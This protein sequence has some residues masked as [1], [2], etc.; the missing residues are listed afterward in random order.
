MTAL[1]LSLLGPGT[2]YTVG[3]FI[4]PTTQKELALVAYLALERRPQ[5]RQHLAELLWG[6]GRGHNLRQALYNLR[7]LPDAE[8]WLVDDGCCVAVQATSDVRDLEL[9]LAAQQYERALYLW[10]PT[11]L[12]QAPKTLLAG[13]EL[14][15]A[16]TFDEWLAL[17]RTRL[18]HLYLEAL[19]GYAEALETR[20]EYAAARRMTEQLLMHDELNETAWQALMRLHHRLGQTDRALATYDECRFV[21]RRE[22]GVEPLPETTALATAL[23]TAARQASRPTVPTL[24][25]PSSGYARAART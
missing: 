10:H 6:E 22:L 5:R 24:P 4:T 13:L 2:L 19:Q 11:S 18:E 8:R 12:D 25:T 14:K 15:G 16:P 20:R 21:I 17:E 7:L 9:A 3:S 1:H 23:R